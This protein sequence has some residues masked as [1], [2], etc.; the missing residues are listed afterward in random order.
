MRPSLWD[1][2]GY[3]IR[4]L[5]PKTSSIDLGTEHKPFRDLYLSGAFVPGA[6]VAVTAAGTTIADATL[7]TAYNN[8]V[9]N[10]AAGTGVQLPTAA[11]GEIVKVTNLGANLLAVYPDSATSTIDGGAAGAA[12]TLLAG[13][14]AEFYY[15]GSGSWRTLSSQRLSQ[16]VGVGLAA[17][18]SAIGDAY[19]IVHEINIFATVNAGEGA[20]LNA[21]TPIGGKVSIA[22]RGANA[23]L[24]YPHDVTADINGTGAGNAVSLAVGEKT[25]I[26]RTAALTWD[27][28]VMVAY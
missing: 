14:S 13:Q 5:L 27:G 21:F 18:G 1:D 8:I 16:T 22:N 6:D 28:G 10:V 26:E 2:V 19:D 12:L 7:L 3:V 23:L 4:T 15:L 11:A 24:I 9:T 20:Q 25:I 17:A